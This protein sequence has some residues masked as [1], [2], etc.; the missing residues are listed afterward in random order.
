MN[1][2]EEIA[3]RLWRNYIRDEYGLEEVNDK[4]AYEYGVYDWSEFT[5]KDKKGFLE[6]ADQ[7]LKMIEKRLDEIIGPYEKYMQ[8]YAVPDLVKEIKEMLK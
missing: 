1:L 7:I 5:D 2:K 8:Y 6:D 4:H 3:K